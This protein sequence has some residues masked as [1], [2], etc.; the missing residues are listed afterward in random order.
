MSMDEKRSIMPWVVSLAAIALIVGVGWYY[1]GHRSSKATVQPA[2]NSTAASSTLVTQ[3]AW[4]IS[5]G[6]PSGWRMTT[7]SSDSVMLASNEG[8]ESWIQLSHVASSGIEEDSAKWGSLWYW[9]SNGKLHARGDLST[10]LA[11]PNI[12]APVGF[13]GG[14]PVYSGISGYNGYVI[15]PRE[16]SF[17]EIGFPPQETQQTIDSFMS[18][19]RAL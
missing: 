18:T 6:L 12:P 5:F 13:S 14:L 3:A 11:V 7:D 16:N 9:W 2:P 4:G 1:L 10:G 17:I 19:I 8:A 15:S